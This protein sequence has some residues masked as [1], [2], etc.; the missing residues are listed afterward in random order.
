MAVR[1]AAIFDVDDTIINTE[2]FRIKVL[3][4][5]CDELNLTPKI[6]RFKYMPEASTEERLKKLYPAHYR[7]M[8]QKWCSIY[9]DEFKNEIRLFAGIKTMLNRLH[10][11]GVL[12]FILSTRDKKMILAALEKHKLKGIFTEI[13]GRKKFGGKKPSPAGIDYIAKKYNLK[14]SNI[15]FVGDSRTDRQTAV[16]GDIRF[17]YATWKNPTRYKHNFYTRRPRPL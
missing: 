3:K 16:K 7:K 17:A 2:E 15:L 9:S 10:K 11:S 8:W 12:L 5:V 6:E 4:K 1:Q 13:L 14:R